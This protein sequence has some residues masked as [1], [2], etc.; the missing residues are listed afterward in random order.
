MKILSISV[1][2]IGFIALA[3]CT[4]DIGANPDLLPKTAEYCDTIT[5]A[6]HIEPI[7]TNQCVTCHFTGGQVPD[8]SN[9]ALIKTQVDGGRIKARVLDQNPSPMPQGG[10]L[11]Q[12][13]LDLVK[14][15]LDAGAPNN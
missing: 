2:A 6:K 7:F 12:P 10:S 13:E 15:W 3:S 4:K 11:T 9:Y 14:C 5:F 8:L 1:I